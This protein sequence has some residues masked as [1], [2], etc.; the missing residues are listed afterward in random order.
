MHLMRSDFALRLVAV[1]VLLTVLLSGCASTQ[2][3][4]GEI[5]ADF[6][7]TQPAD[8]VV[9]APASDAERDDE[10]LLETTFVWT[11]PGLNP[12]AVRYSVTDV[13]FGRNEA[14]RERIDEDEQ[15]EL[16]KLLSTALTEA[17]A[18][19]PSAGSRTLQVHALISRVETPNRLFNAISLIAPLPPFFI[20][21]GAAIEVEMRDLGSGER[22]I[23]YGCATAGGPIQ[24]TGYFLRLTHAKFALQECS[25]S[26]AKLLGLAK[27]EAPAD[28][29]PQP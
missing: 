22:E 23:V 19:E 26:L 29:K 18:T 10:K 13:R 9:R 7:S 15:V 14:S 11:K 2:L 24:F 12:E 1:P 20:N 6:R 16:T 4:N 25:R 27:D 5:L 17:L 8:A 3:T 21:G 28:V